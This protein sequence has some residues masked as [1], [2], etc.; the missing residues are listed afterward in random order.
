MAYNIL[1]VME[2]WLNVVNLD[3]ANEYNMND[4]GTNNIDMIYVKSMI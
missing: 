1:N 4:I 3:V 2:L